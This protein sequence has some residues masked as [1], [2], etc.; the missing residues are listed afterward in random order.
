MSTLIDRYRE[1]RTATR[2]RRAIG[3]ALDRHASPA[4]RDRLMDTARH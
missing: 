1:H 4:V 3:R 2:R